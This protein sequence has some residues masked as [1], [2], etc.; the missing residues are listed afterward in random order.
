MVEAFLVSLREKLRQH[1]EEL[2]RDALYGPPLLNTRFVPYM[3]PT[4]SIVPSALPLA[5]QFETHETIAA[6]VHHPASPA[7][8]PRPA[9]RR[10]RRRWIWRFIGRFLDRLIEPRPSVTLLRKPRR[11]KRRNRR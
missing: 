8:V 9:P 3:P 5:G 10:K 1:K 2:R 6:F 4:P 7:Q 11:R